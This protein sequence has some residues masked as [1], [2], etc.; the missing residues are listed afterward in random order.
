MV[1]KYVFF[2]CISECISHILNYLIN[3]D[4]GGRGGGGE[5]QVWRLLCQATFKPWRHAE[6]SDYQLM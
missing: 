2:K 4:Q 6:N 3:N 5:G 1:E